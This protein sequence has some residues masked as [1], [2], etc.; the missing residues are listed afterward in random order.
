MLENSQHNFNI[1]AQV[2][3]KCSYHLPAAHSIVNI[4]FGKFLAC[5]QH[6]VS[7]VADL[8]VLRTPAVQHCREL[9]PLR[10]GVGPP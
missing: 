2:E 8:D 5:C 7:D 3:H 4:L 1:R 10:L 9:G 6:Y